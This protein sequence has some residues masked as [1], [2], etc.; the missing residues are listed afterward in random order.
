M[1][2]RRY[3]VLQKVKRQVLEEMQ[4]IEDLEL[5]HGPGIH[6]GSWS[7]SPMDKEDSRTCFQ[8]LALPIG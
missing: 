8:E 5:S 1:T 2:K 7:V 3:E 4:H 6:W